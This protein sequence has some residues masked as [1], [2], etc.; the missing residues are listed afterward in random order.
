MKKYL[1]VASIL[2]SVGATSQTNTFPF[3]SSGNVGIGTTNPAALLHI[4]NGAMMASDPSFNTI[5]LRLDASSSIPV[6]NFTRWTGTGSLQHNAFV[7]QFYNSSLGE[8][9]FGLGT[10]YSTT[11]DQN[12]ISNVITIPLNGNVGIGTT[13]PAYK[14]DVNGTGNFSGVLTGTSATFSGQLNTNFA[15]TSVPSTSNSSQYFIGAAYGNT[16]WAGQ[17]FSG[18]TAHDWYVGMLPNSVSGSTDAYGMG[19]VSGGAF[20]PKLVFNSTG[21]ATFS[22]SVT[23]GTNLLWSTDGGGSIGSG[24][25]RPLNISMAGGLGVNAAVG[26]AGTINSYTDI[27]IHNGWLYAGTTAN[28]NGQRYG[29]QVYSFDAS[30]QFTGTMQMDYGTQPYLHLK[31]T[32]NYVQIDQ[33]L[34]LLGALTGTNANFSGNVGIGTISPSEKLSVNGNI[35]TKKLIVTQTGW[36]DYV[37]NN[38]Y[39]LKPL[40]EVENYIKANKHLPDMPSAKEVEIKGISVGDNQALLLKKIEELTLYIIEM[41]KEINELKQNKNK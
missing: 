15:S 12:A 18:A 39:K 41:Q 35:R 23:L 6:I 22:S 13:N 8:Y 36:P 2:L 17:Y 31:T 26:A 28:I 27:S 16:Y 21:A 10:G 11:G 14:L 19:I 30:A 9:S 4:R 7:G 33:P 34:T 25:N 32:G 40:A 20:T 24:S 3:P 29:V 1:L 37:F 5:N 38:D